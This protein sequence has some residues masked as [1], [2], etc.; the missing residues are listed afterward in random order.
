MSAGMV[1]KL[2]LQIEMRLG[3]KTLLP[4]HITVIFRSRYFWF[5]RPQIHS[6]YNGKQLDKGFLHN[7]QCVVSEFKRILEI[8][9]NEKRPLY[10]FLDAVDSLSEEDG[11]HGLYWLPGYLSPHVKVVVSTASSCGCHTAAKGLLQDVE[12]NVIQVCVCVC[13]CVRACVC[14]CVHVCACVRA[15]VHVC[16]CI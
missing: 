2:D 3:M 16:V 11:A 8:L 7:Y 4:S 13:V 6:V 9:P 12:E 5:Q 10:L 14:V 15:C 1:P